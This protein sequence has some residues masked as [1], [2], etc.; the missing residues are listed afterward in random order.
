[1]QK[2]FLTF[3]YLGLIKPAPGTWGS[4]GGAICGYFIYQYISAT[5]LFLAS[6]LLCLVSINIINDYEKKI[7][8]HDAS[9]IVID[10]V[11]GVWLAI[12]ICG[13]DILA[14]LFSLLFFR[15]FDI[16]KPSVIGRIDKN[17]NGGLGVMGDDMAAGAVAGVFSA[18]LYQ[19]LSH[20]GLV[21]IINE[22]F[23]A[24]L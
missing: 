1:M 10:E 21:K 24:I 23:S 7:K 19:I 3:F 22:Y 15:I 9:F 13:Y 11:A 14:T 5:T 12:S 8:I 2:L 16:T 18:V 20:F 17:I 6:I 4:I